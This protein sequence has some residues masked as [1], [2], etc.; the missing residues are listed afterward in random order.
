MLSRMTISIRLIFLLLSIDHRSRLP[1]FVVWILD[2]QSEIN[3]VGFNVV[4]YEIVQ[5]VLKLEPRLQC[6]LLEN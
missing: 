1:A 6:G 2:L 4:D 5:Y 3:I